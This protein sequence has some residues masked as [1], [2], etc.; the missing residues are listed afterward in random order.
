MAIGPQVFHGAMELRL[1][2]RENAGC[3]AVGCAHHHMEIWMCT[4]A[5]MWVTQS[6]TQ[7]AVHKAET[8]IQEEANIE[9]RDQPSF[10]RKDRP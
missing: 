3:L 10:S 6:H 5:A 9:I 4:H 1:R 2:S 7:S 8:D